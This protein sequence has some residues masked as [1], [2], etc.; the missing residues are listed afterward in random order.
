M[1]AEFL[2]FG[3]YIPENFSS[4]S[5]NTWFFMADLTDAEETAL[6][7]IMAASIKQ[8][9]FSHGPT[10]RIVKKVCSLCFLD[11]LIGDKQE[12]ILA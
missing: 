6:I 10:G 9:A 7:E 1:Q 2:K 12:A 11:L 8:A 4:E 5:N 3:T